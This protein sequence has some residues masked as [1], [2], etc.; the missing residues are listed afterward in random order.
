VAPVQTPSVDELLYRSLAGFGGSKPVPLSEPPPYLLKNVD[1]TAGISEVAAAMR[2]SNMLRQDYAPPEPAAPKYPP[3]RGSG[4]RVPIIPEPERPVPSLTD[5]L[6]APQPARSQSIFMLER[7]ASAAA[8][9]R[10]SVADKRPALDSN[11]G[12]D[13]EG[14]RALGAGRN[15]TTSTTVV[16]RHASMDKP[17]S[18]IS[19]AGP[20]TDQPVDEFAMYRRLGFDPNGPSKF[21]IGLKYVLDWSNYFGTAK[22]ATLAFKRHFGEKVEPHNNAAD[23]FRH[24]LWSYKMTKA[25]GPEFAKEVA[26]SLEVTHPS[27]PGDRLMDLYN[28]KI[29]R[30]L[31]MDPTNLARPGDQVILEALQQGKL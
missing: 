5:F 16:E 26:D 23:A 27:E 9:P 8:P 30:Q 24:A 12:P 25:K 15:E 10:P 22:E 1:R 7:L 4:Y 14:Q 28:N 20:P 19:D 6:G 11:A 17:R 31:A 18:V 13:M 2:L 21:E 3:L 29:G